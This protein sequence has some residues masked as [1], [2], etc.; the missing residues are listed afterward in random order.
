ME[1][2]GPKPRVDAYIRPSEV[3]RPHWMILGDSLGHDP[4]S[5]DM[6]DQVQH[7]ERN[8]GRLLHPRI[9]DK[10]PLPIILFDRPPF[11]DSVIGEELHALVLAFVGTRPSGEAEEKRNLALAVEVAQADWDATL[12]EFGSVSC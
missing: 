10:R 12:E 11:L 6:R 1:H 4:R 5:L 2:R 8:R 9:P 3:V 7:R